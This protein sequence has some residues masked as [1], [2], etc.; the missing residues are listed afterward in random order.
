[1]VTTTNSSD[2]T[3]RTPTCPLRGAWNTW[4]RQ[5][6]HINKSWWK[7]DT[8]SR[9]VAENFH[10]PST[11][12]LQRWQ[13]GLETPQCFVTP[14]VKLFTSQES[15]IQGISC[16]R[17]STVMLLSP[18]HRPA[19]ILGVQ[20]DLNPSSHQPGE[21]TLLT[22]RGGL[23]SPS[24]ITAVLQINFCTQAEQDIPLSQMV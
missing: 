4:T 23:L 21:S 10:V 9:L 22:S 12:T 1:M 14:F 8:S 19:S 6:Q 24:H 13:H 15:I 2:I 3:V 20:E 7:R 5:S 17:F 11:G 18:C 16:I